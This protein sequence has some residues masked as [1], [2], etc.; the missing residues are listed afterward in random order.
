MSSKWREVE[1]I[2]AMLHKLIFGPEWDIKSPERIPDKITGQLREVDVSL[3]LKSGYISILIIVEYRDRDIEDVTWIE[4]LVTK[5]KNLGADKII[6][7][8]SNGFT[9]PAKKSAEHYGI[10]THVLSNITPD[11]I[12]SWLNGSSVS[13]ASGFCCFANISLKLKVFEHIYPVTNIE[14][15]LFLFENGNYNFNDIFRMEVLDKHQ[16]LFSD[17]GINGSKTIKKI[18]LPIQNKYSIKAD[19]LEIYL[20]ESFV[21]EVELWYE[22]QKIPFSKMFRFGDKDNIIIEWAGTEPVDLGNGPVKLSIS[23][24]KG[25]D[26]MNLGIEFLD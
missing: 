15:K 3:R 22:Q 14:D 18:D 24:Q 11:D 19:N 13:A 10:A 12:K 9:E 17:V 5:C 23:K 1:I 16:D 7:V 6:A 8:S 2:V 21:V 25:S 4:Q 26:G 20:I